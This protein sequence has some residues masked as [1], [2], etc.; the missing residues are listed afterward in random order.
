MAVVEKAM[1]HRA[2]K[3]RMKTACKKS[4]GCKI[5]LPFDTSRLF[6]DLPARAQAGAS[7]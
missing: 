4:L 1:G 3:V 5:R 2:V 7:A 6:P